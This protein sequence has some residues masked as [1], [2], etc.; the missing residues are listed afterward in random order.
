[1]K[2]NWVLG[3]GI[4][5][6]LV[7]ASLLVSFGLLYLRPHL[8]VRHLVEGRCAVESVAYTNEMVQCTC[9]SDGGSSCVSQY[10]CLRVVV[11]ISR[12]GGG[13]VVAENATLYDSYETF[14]LQASALQCSYH[15]CSRSASD[16]LEAVQTFEARFQ[17]GDERRIIANAG[18]CYFDP[19]DPGYSLLEIVGTAT[20]INA[21]IW[22]GLATVVGLIIFF[23]Q[24]FHADAERWNQKTARQ[25]GSLERQ[26]ARI[27]ERNY[28]RI[29]TA[30]TAAGGCAERL[31][32]AEPGGTRTNASASQNVVSLAH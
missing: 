3:A 16:N 26:W 9:A 18:R 29:T 21:I 14:V 11:N 15:K 25:F 17:R 30:S 20:A 2:L 32:S 19:D 28:G 8:D 12:A 4:I 27:R 7:G 5:L 22:P 13:S 6:A 24:I 1:M 31:V 10:P 23:F